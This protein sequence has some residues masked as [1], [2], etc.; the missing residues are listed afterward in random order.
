VHNGPASQIAMLLGATGANVTTSGGDY[1]FEQALL[2]AESLLEDTGQSALLLSADEGHETLSFLLDSSIAPGSRLADGGGALSINRDPVNARCLV[3]LLFYGRDTG[4]EL[5][6]ALIEALGEADCAVRDY[7]AVFAG[8]PAGMADRGNRQ[9]AGFLGYTNQRIP[10]C[11]YRDFLGEFASASAV[12]AVLA[13]AYLEA[14]IL[15]GALFGGDNI[16]INHGQKIL[17]LG[18]GSFI[19]AMEFSRP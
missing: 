18:T 13:V 8:I 3:R 1:S 11:R 4:G 10:V 5:P 14:G 19:T 16:Y 9:L 15:P 6:D 12:A 7:A 2:A 17:V